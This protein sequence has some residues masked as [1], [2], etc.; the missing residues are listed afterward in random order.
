MTNRI[1]CYP[2]PP[3]AGEDVTICHEWDP[4]DPGASLDLDVTFT[5]VT[6]SGIYPITCPM[7][8]SMACVKLTVPQAAYAMTVAATPGDADVLTRAVSQ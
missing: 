4:A 3:K 6:G 5:P 8:G 2:D 7:V 1:T